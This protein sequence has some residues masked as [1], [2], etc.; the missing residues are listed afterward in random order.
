MYAFLAKRM[1]LFCFA[2]NMMLTA[3]E[4]GWCPRVCMGKG[5]GTHKDNVFGGMLANIS[6]SYYDKYEKLKLMN[7]EMQETPFQRPGHFWVP[8]QMRVLQVA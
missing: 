8:G 5:K 1:G 4:W 7:M 3:N 2:F 6:R